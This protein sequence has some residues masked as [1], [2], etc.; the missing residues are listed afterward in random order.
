[1]LGFFS[2][3]ADEYIEAGQGEKIESLYNM[4]LDSEFCKSI[5]DSLKAPQ[6]DEGAAAKSVNGFLKMYQAV[7]QGNKPD[8]LSELFERTAHSINAEFENVLVNGNTNVKFTYNMNQ[9]FKNLE[10]F[11]G[12]EADRGY[13][14]ENVLVNMVFVIPPHEGVFK[15]FFE[16]A[17]FYNILKISLPA[18]LKENWSDEDL[19][20]AITYSAK[21]VVNTK[22]T[23]RVSEKDFV[24]HDSF[25][26]PHIAFMIS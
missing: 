5:A 20:L 21:M 2:K 17:M 19:A 16:L 7:R 8:S 3:K 18:F 11:R 26:L 6:S 1:M 9:Y 15:S 22:M 12:I 24:E 10:I 23:E 13:I 14:F 4:M 25:D